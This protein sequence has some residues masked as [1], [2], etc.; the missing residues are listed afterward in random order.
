MYED[1]LLHSQ[2]CGQDHN[3]TARNGRLFSPIAVVV[4]N[5]GRTVICPISSLLMFSASGSKATQFAP[6]FPLVFPVEHGRNRA[7]PLL[8]DLRLSL[9]GRQVE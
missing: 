5:T 9:R 7:Q 1:T 6:R 8:M 2:Y 4:C 3:Q